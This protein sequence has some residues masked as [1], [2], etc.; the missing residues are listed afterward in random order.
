VLTA[1]SCTLA[2]G[3]LAADWISLSGQQAGT[4]LLEYSTLA[5][6]ILVPVAAG[7]PS[8]R[9]VAVPGDP[10]G[11][12]R[13]GL[14]ALTTAVLVGPAMQAAGFAEGTADRVIL[15]SGSGV[16]FVLVLVR[17]RGLM[18]DI[19]E[20]RRTEAMLREAEEH[21]R[22]LIEGLPAVVYAA[23]L[24]REGK[25]LYVSPRVTP[26][27][28]YTPD[29]WLTDPFLWENN[30]HP[31]DLEGVMETVARCTRSGDRFLAEYRF[32]VGDGRERWIRDEGS[33]I[34]ARRPGA[35]RVIRGVMYDV[36]EQHE[37]EERLRVALQR[38][39]SAS[40]HLRELDDMK[41]SILNAVSHELRTPLTSILGMSRMLQDEAGRLG[42]DDQHLFIERIG[43]NADRLNR[44]IADLLDLDRL[45]RGILE[46]NRQP[47]EL[48]GAVAKLLEEISL[49]G[50][51]LTVDVAPLVANLDAAQ[52]ERIVVNL[53]SNA[54]R[55]T[56]PASPIRLRV[57]RDDTGVLIEV[58]DSGPGVPDAIK[59]RIFEPFR[60]GEVIVAHSPGVG[61]GLSLVAK[62]AALHGGRAWVEDRPGGGASF[63]VSLPADQVRPLL[64][65]ASSV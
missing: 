14:L 38:E 55:Y 50:R 17:M 11:G 8:M 10:K 54:V 59:A 28:G 61:I 62:F 43:V 34:A 24:G 25:W 63:K 3:E 9:D 29:Q 45:S 27:L 47:I 30:V 51:P 1:A 6:F 23:E 53:V 13:P 44:L 33:I 39:Q 4:S 26:V 64:T 46:P 52:F 5:F 20:H 56:P 7:Y 58:D 36:T 15:A 22:T 19:R 41:N 12:H 60:Q 16:L 49:D 31:E 57:G 65:V 21:Y 18:V 48:P 32:R 42:Q 35:N 37:A 2:L 40:R